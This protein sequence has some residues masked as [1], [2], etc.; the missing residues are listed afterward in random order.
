MSYLEN[1]SGPWFLSSRCV[2]FHDISSVCRGRK[3]WRN[4]NIHPT[5]V[6]YRNEV[7][8][9]PQLL[10]VLGNASCLIGQPVQQSRVVGSSP[11]RS[12]IFAAIGKL[13][14]GLI[15]ISSK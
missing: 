9:S 4:E 2:S 15:I 1:I 3:I 12:I 13:M 6:A 14:C 8:F 10:Y 7:L 11:I 5:L